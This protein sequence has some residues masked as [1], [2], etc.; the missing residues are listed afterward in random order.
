MAESWQ[1]A[2]PLGTSEGDRSLCSRQRGER[3]LRELPLQTMLDLRLNAANAACARRLPTRSDS[4]CRWSQYVCR[5]ARGAAR[6]GSVPTSGWSSRLPMTCRRS[7]AALAAT[8]HRIVDVSDLRAGFQLAGPLSRDVLRKG[9]A[10][11]LHPRAFATGAVR[12]DRARPRAGDS[13]SARANAAY[14]IYVERSV[15]GYADAGAMGEYCRANA[16]SRWNRH[17]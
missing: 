6:C 15:A 9:C 11:D 1:C 8:L 4:S 16:Q 7:R 13:C 3:G 2:S 12:A 14:D 10:V 5:G 17:I